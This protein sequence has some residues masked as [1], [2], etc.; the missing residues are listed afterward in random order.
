MLLHL[1]SNKYLD[2]IFL[3]ALLSPVNLKSSPG[4]QARPYK[5]N[6]R[7]QARAAWS[8]GSNGSAMAD[9]PGAGGLGSAAQLGAEQRWQRRARPQTGRGRAVARWPGKGGWADLAARRPV[10]MV[11]SCSILSSHLIFLMQ[12]RR[13]TKPEVRADAFFP[14]KLLLQASGG[15]VPL[16]SFVPNGQTSVPNRP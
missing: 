3:H 8:G 16:I 1:G 13:K 15:K 12:A 7:K 11:I 6:K 9:W 10:L 14:V 2:N 5:K 4:K